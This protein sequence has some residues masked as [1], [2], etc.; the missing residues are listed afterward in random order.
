MKIVLGL[1]NPGDRYAATRHNIGWMVLDAIAER[2][3][4]R[5]QPGQGDYWKAEIRWHGAQALL[6]KPMTY[7]NNSGVAARQII[8]RYGVGIEDI[9]VIVDE[10]QL[11]TG[12]I[13]VRPSGS[14]GGHNGLESLIYQLESDAFPR[15]RCG[16]GNAFERGRMVE[17]VLASFPAEERERVEEMIRL[18]SEAV[19]T[20]IAE[21]TMEAM[22]RHNV[23]PRPSAETG[24]QATEPT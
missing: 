11:P 21:G 10:L 3:G 9:L 7:M 5:F 15:V 23:H 18:A 1:G 20:W 14:S 6:V 8:D 13:R 2:L 4:A 22:S 19:L 17:Y 12:R 24:D 16:V